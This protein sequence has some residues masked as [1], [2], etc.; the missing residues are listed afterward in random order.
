MGI[1]APEYFVY[2]RIIFIKLK[3]NSFISGYRPFGNSYMIIVFNVIY[4]MT[5]N[6]S[7]FN[8]NTDMNGFEKQLS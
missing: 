1:W 3:D 6:E 5:N 2:E 8:E 7:E 4:R